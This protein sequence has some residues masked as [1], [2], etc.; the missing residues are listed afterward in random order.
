[1]GENCT[2]TITVLVIHI[3]HKNDLALPSLR[4]KSRKETLHS[5][6]RE[7]YITNVP[8]NLAMSSILNG[9]KLNYTAKDH[10]RK[11]S[12]ALD[13]N[14]FRGTAVESSL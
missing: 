3:L 6:R 14:G 8:N 4:G 12:L 2:E 11:S 5:D 7:Y 10:W 9:S 1:M 13:N